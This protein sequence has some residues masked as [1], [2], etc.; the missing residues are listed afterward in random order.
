MDDLVAASLRFLV[1]LIDTGADGDRDRRV[2][3]GGGVVGDQLIDGQGDRTLK[4][5]PK[6]GMSGGDTGR[7]AAASKESTWR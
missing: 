7:V 6:N 2:M 3:R 5:C 1:S 4:R